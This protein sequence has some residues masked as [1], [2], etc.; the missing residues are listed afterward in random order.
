VSYTMGIV[1]NTEPLLLTHRQTVTV[2]W[3]W[4]VEVVVKE[5]LEVVFWLL[6]RYS[7]QNSV[8]VSCFP[9]LS[10]KSSKTLLHLTALIIVLTLF[11]SQSSFLCNTLH[12][13]LISSH[14]NM[15][16]KWIKIAFVW[17]IIILF[18]YIRPTQIWKDYAYWQ[19]FHWQ[20]G[21]TLNRGMPDNVKLHLELDF[22][23][24]SLCV[25]C[26]LLGCDAMYSCRYLPAFLWNTCNHEQD[27]AVYPE[28]HSPYFHNHRNLKSHTNLLFSSSQGSV[29]KN[30]S[31]LESVWLW[32][33]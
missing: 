6:W 24:T 11:E 13:L 17:R 5:C 15:K 18:S 8:F 21:I 19:T 29:H 7:H 14:L 16:I 12:S 20:W 32:W 28:D 4:T 23:D 3:V 22:L 9:D 30:V 10:H 31:A 25:D 33:W 1:D 26:G 27:C 2:D